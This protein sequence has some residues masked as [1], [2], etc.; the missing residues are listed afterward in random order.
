MADN[1]AREERS[2]TMSRIR[3]TDTKLEPIVRRLTFSRGLRYRKYDSG[4]P[5]TPGLVF[6]EPKVEVFVDG[7]SWHSWRSDEWEHKF[8]SKFW[9]E[10]IARNRRR[11]GENL[12][13][14]EEDGWTVIRIWEREIG[15]DAEGLRG[16][17]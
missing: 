17:H 14:L 10:K 7:D 11:D 5:G 13:Q 12:R 9:K 3:K 16:S 1:M 6:A 15:E 8:S 4:L 2:R